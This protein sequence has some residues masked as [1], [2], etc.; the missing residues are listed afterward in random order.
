[1]L[2]T[3][4][5]LSPWQAYLRLMLSRQF[6]DHNWKRRYVYPF[7]YLMVRWGESGWEAKRPSKTDE[8]IIQDREDNATW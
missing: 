3:I 4:G 2:E 7:G 5:T 6:D 1:M 8:E